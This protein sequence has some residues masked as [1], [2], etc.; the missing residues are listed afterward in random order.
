MSESHF[1]APYELNPPGFCQNC[2]SMRS[3]VLL[4]RGLGNQANAGR[5][6]QRCIAEVRV[7]GIS[8]PCTSMWWRDDL[9]RK[10]GVSA[11]PPTSFPSSTATPS[12]STPSTP[13]ALS[14]DTVCSGPA[15]AGKTPRK[16]NRDCSFR[17]CKA[18]C[19]HH[20]REGTRRCTVSSHK[21]V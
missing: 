18:C 5:W 21:E 12:F 17:L 4:C 19:S 3:P 1:L 9:K 13:S 8:N 16:L 11:S 20:Q 15:C 7:P 6:Y 10:H 2:G 14:A